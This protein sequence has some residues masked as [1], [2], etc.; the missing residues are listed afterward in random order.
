MRVT[1]KDRFGAWLDG[2]SGMLRRKGDEAQ[3]EI[4]A[5]DLPEPRDAAEEALWQ[6]MGWSEPQ[7]RDS[8]AIAAEAVDGI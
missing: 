5:K 8:L 6:A 4:A 1:V 7:E 3:R 2:L